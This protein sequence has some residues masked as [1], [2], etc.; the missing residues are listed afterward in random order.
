VI[1]PRCDSL[2][3]ADQMEM[4]PVS[5]A[6]LMRDTP[7]LQ[8][9]D[10]NDGSDH[11]DTEILCGCLS[12]EQTV[13]EPLLA[14]LPPVFRISLCEANGK[15]GMDSLL[16]HAVN[17]VTSDDS[18]ADDARLRITELLFVEALRRYTQSLPAEE[19]GWL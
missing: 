11:A 4:E 18:G 19:T 5:A 16:E 6:A 15:P 8:L 3:L 17:E 12:S 9:R 10:V 13:L 14:S 7:L 1:L 2:V